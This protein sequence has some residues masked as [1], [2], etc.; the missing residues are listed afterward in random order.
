[1][2]SFSSSTVIFTQSGDFQYDCND[3]VGW[4][5]ALLKGTLLREQST[6]LPP[7]NPAKIC[8]VLCV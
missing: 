7:D 8:T 3:A 1:M 2:L 6:N 4:L 5:S